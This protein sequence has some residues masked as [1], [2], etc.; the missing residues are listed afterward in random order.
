MHKG[1]N[2]REDLVA[3]KAWFLSN[4]QERVETFPFKAFVSRARRVDAETMEAEM[5]KNLADMEKVR[6]CCRA[7]IENVINITKTFKHILF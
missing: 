1:W 4:V 6:F 7:G 2:M 5:V 3:E